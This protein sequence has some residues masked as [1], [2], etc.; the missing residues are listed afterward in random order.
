MS[1]RGGGNG[2]N[3]VYQV[4]TPGTLPTAATAASTQ[5]NILPGF[6]TFLANAKTPPAPFTFGF[7][8]FGIWF[9]NANTLYLADEG[10]GVIADA[11]KDTVS[12][13]EKWSFNGTQWVLDYTLQAGLGLGNYPATATDGLR[14]ITGIVNGD[15][16]VTIYGVT[17]TVSTSSDQGADPDEIVAV[18][19]VLADTVPPPPEMFSVL[20]G[21]QYGVVYRGVSFDPV[22]ELRT[23]ALLGSALLVLGIMRWRR[24]RAYLSSHASSKRQPL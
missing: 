23:I 18:T 10:D 19:D 14:N 12:G 17:S 9:A 20:D 15:G 5:V 21:P 3:T 7:F 13:L 2:I 6:P 22:P 1:P 16:T 8:P 4:G 24:A 11:S